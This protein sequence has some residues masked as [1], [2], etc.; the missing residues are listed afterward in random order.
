MN[1]RNALDLYDAYYF[2]T[3]CGR[4]YQ[5]DEGWL[6]LFGSIADR[7]VR[8]IRP[9]T[10]LDVGCA[11]GFLVE[12]L[13]QRGVDAFGV[14]VSEYA[15]QNVHPDIQPY[16]WVASVTDPPPRTYDLIVCIEVLEHLFG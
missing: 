4:P 7:I 16:C 14:D 13:R 12:A 6:R 2:A 3:G 1:S 5:R 11:M 9:S 15:I 8:D 10:V